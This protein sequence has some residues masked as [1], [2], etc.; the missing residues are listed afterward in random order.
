M[1]KMI[2]YIVV[3]CVC[4]VSFNAKASDFV[5]DGIYFTTKSDST[6]AVTHNGMT[7]EMIYP[8]GLAYKGIVNVP[9]TVEYDSKTYKVTAIDD[10]AFSMCTK[11]TYVVLPDGI[12]RI[13]NNAFNGCEN[14]TSIVLGEG[15]LGIGEYAFRD[16]YYLAS[17]PV[18]P[19]VTYIGKGAFSYCTSMKSMV[20]PGGV[21]IIDNF[22]FHG[23]TY[24]EDV[25]L[26]ASVAAIGQNAFSECTSMRKLDLPER[27]RSIGRSAFADCA[28]LEEINI[29]ENVTEI[30]NYAFRDCEMLTTMA[31]PNNV[32]TL[33]SYIFSGCY[34]LVDVTVS[35]SL[36]SI[37]DYAFSYCNSLL[38]LSLPASLKTI[39][40]AAFCECCNMTE[41]VLPKGIVAIEPYT[42]SE[43][44]ALKTVTIPSTVKTIGDGAFA[45]CEALAV[46]NNYAIRPQELGEDVFATFGELHITENHT[47]FFADSMPWSEFTIVDDLPYVRVNEIR[48]WTETFSCNRR[49]VCQAVAICYPEDAIYKTVEW[50]SSNPDVVYIDHQTGQFVGVRQGTATITATATDDSGIQA[51]ATIIVGNGE[52][53]VPTVSDRCVKPTISYLDGQLVFESPTFGAVYHCTITDADA[54]KEVKSDGRLPLNGT[55]SITVYATAEGYLPSETSYATLHW[56]NK[57]VDTALPAIAA[58][59]RAI[60]CTVRDGNVCIEGL[61]V[62]EEVSFYTSA[63]RHLGTTLARKGTLDVNLSGY[64]GTVILVQ[65]KDDCLKILVK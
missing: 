48:L 8:D 33:G 38:N 41:V 6:C 62:N 55:L 42:F 10:Y 34:S 49:D 24:L 40:E 1:K 15:L 53:E 22:V 20:I 59:R 46:V 21:T 2:K 23:C 37:G 51:S 63:G 19:T 9:S 50:K 30:G 39:G 56:L 60:F 27:V 28:A 65:I 47:A 25:S 7:N 26:P 11:L 29:P 61:D 32:V 64:K 54:M 52:N 13:G 16:C 5:L 35:Q 36:T 31:L 18:P 43:C 44:Y 12:T 17:F 58:D 3:L 45:G 4:M 57:N 14:L